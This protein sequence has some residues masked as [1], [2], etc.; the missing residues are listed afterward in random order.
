[1][2]QTKKTTGFVDLGD[3]T[4]ENTEASEALVFMVVGLQG[5]WYF[6][7]SNPNMFASSWHALHALEKRGINAV[8]LAMNRNASN[9][10]MCTMLGC[11]IRLNLE[12]LKTYFARSSSGEWVFVIMDACHMLKLARN[13]MQAY[14]PIRVLLAKL[15]GI[16][17]WS[18][19]CSAKGLSD[20]PMTAGEDGVDCSPFQDACGVVLHHNYLHTCL[21]ALTENALVYTSG[22]VMRSVSPK[23]RC[24]VRHSSLVTCSTSQQN[25]G[26][27]EPAAFQMR[28]RN[29]VFLASTSLYTVW[30]WLRKS[31]FLAPT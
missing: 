29:A 6:V 9:V 17:C 10:S 28:F 20:S 3:G 8:C 12:P 4:D 18:K 23:L 26:S 15:T 7:T 13:M 5:H 25:A 1:M 14:S 31:T 21:R 11:Q 22:F 30:D 19:W 16:Y 2:T 27:S 24:E